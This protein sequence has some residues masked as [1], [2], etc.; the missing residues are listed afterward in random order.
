[1]ACVPIVCTNPSPHTFFTQL[2]RHGRLYPLLSPSSHP[3]VLGTVLSWC[4]SPQTFGTQVV[5]LA[6][7]LTQL[8]SSLLFPSSHSSPGSRNPLPHRI[9]WQVAL[10]PKPYG[11]SV[12]PGSWTGSHSSPGST[13]P[14]PQRTNLQLTQLTVSPPVS[15]SSLSSGLIL[16]SPQTD[17]VQS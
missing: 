16:P 6:L 17:S 13:L 5:G 3:S 14:S 4:P 2:G 15:Q 12:G 7:L 1:S 9:Q 11:P 8:S 10:Q